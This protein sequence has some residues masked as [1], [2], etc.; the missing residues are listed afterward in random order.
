MKEPCFQCGR[1]SSKCSVWWKSWWVIE[2]CWTRWMY[3]KPQAQWCCP[4]WSGDWYILCFCEGMHENIPVARVCRHVMTKSSNQGSLISVGRP[5]SPD[6]RR[7][8]VRCFNPRKIQRLS[9]NILTNFVQLSVKRKAGILYGGWNS[10]R[11]CMR[12]ALRLSSK[13]AVLLLALSN[14]RSW[15]LRIGSLQLFLAVR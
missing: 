14:G 6:L 8:C 5:I 4:S 10:R 13:R 11:R 7:H 15:T 12:H 9:K 2:G 3:R 1:R